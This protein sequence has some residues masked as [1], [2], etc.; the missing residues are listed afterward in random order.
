MVSIVRESLSHGLMITGF[1]F[2]MML[3]VE[4][5]N[6]FTRGVWERGLRGNRWRQYLLA[7]LL[8]ATPGCLGAF[9]VA[10]LYAHGVV[11]VGALVAC[12]VAT[13]GDEAFVMLALMPAKAIGIFG[14]LFALGVGAG[15]AADAVFGRKK[16]EAQECVPGL[17]VHEESL[18][19]CLPWGRIWEQWRNCTLARGVL[20][21]SLG[22]F[23]FGL[24]SDRLGPPSWNWVKVS[25]LVTA[26]CGLFIV[27]TVPDHFL[28]EHL[29]EHVAK[30]HAP[31]VFLWTIG[32][33]IAMRVMVDHLHLG[34]WLHANRL[35]VL[36]VACLAGIIPESGPHL[37][38]VTLYASGTLPLSV[39]L[40]SSVVQDGHG[41][42]PVLAES[43]GDFV[44]VKAANFAAGLL[45]GLVGYGAGW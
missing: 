15:F 3:L 2:V 9:A 12:M 8:G 26:G 5:L 38:F 39:L 28:E 34:T 19:H 23:L 21:L 36:L 6:V 37:I 13:S 27:S 35:I 4:Y 14:L 18:C 10:A 33:L 20:I 16:A 31:K 29:W 11:T 1:V 40:A 30:V 24:L 45:L 32:A 42:L 17:G 44:R 43:R 41:M 22:L 25:L 7:A